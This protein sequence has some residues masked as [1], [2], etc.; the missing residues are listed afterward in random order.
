MPNPVADFYR[1]HPRMVSSPFGGVDG[2]NRE[3]LEDVFERLDIR[4][5]GK[6]VLDVGCGR[7][8]TREVVEGLGGQYTGTDFVASSSGFRLVLA[9]AG[10]LPFPDDHFDAVFCIDAYEHFPRP[11]LAAIEFGRVLRPGG[12]MYLSSPNYGNIAGIVKWVYE[13]LG[14]YAK[15]TWAP[16]GRWTPQEL[17][18]PLTGR[19][20]K[21]L[22]RGAGFGPISRIGHGP[23]VG[24]GLFPWIDHPKMPEAI[25]FRLQRLFG[26]IG[27]GIARMCPAASLHSFWKMER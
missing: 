23:E 17:E 10:Q 8:F 16:F 15:N 5:D 1:A 13:A 9:D 2:I 26:I 22:Y 20:V 27:P 7:G 25:Q 21:R 4:L 19:M 24:L 6:H 14:W 12:F 3:L 18:T 11:D